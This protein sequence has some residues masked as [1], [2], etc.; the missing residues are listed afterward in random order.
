MK[1]LS[2]GIL[3]L[4]IVGQLSASNLDLAL[5]VKWSSFDHR[6]QNGNYLTKE[7]L[8]IVI[9]PI[10]NR[11]S[12]EILRQDEV[13]EMQNY[14]LAGLVLIVGGSIIFSLAYVY[15]KKKIVSKQAQRAQQN[16]AQMRQLEADVW[17]GWLL[18]TLYIDTVLYLL[19]YVFKCVIM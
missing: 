3:L 10:V 1:T 12:T 8:E 11:I 9:N 6:G 7:F 5:G 14:T 19:D 13:D 16:A 2:H 17:N 15:L 4:I 18:E